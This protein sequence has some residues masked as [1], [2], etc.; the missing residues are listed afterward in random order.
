MENAILLSSIVIIRNHL[1]RAWKE[2]NATQ[3]VGS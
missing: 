1:K 2:L 3:E